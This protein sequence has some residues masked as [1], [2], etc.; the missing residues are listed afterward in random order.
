[1]KRKR[2]G[3]ANLVHFLCNFKLET[4]FYVFFGQFLPSSLTPQRQR[5]N[6]QRICHVGHH[7]SSTLT[8]YEDHQ[9]TVVLGMHLT[10]RYLRVPECPLRMHT[11]RSTQSVVERVLV[12]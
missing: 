4:D 1:M 3:R 11:D 6:A 10:T 7:G 12:K 5:V 8:R 9:T 2:S